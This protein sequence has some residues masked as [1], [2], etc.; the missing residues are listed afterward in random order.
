VHGVVDRQ[1]MEVIRRLDRAEFVC[2]GS[3]SAI[4]QKPERFSF[5]STCSSSLISRTRLPSL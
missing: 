4:Q 5:S 1:R 2:G 3:L